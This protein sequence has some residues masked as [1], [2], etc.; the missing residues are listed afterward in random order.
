MFS[1]STPENVGISSRQ[2]LKYLKMIESHGLFSH[3]ILIARGDKLICEAYW[4]PFDSKTRHRMYSQTKS[5]VG[6]AIRLLDYEGR[7]SLD[8]RIIDY[9]P[10]KLPE[11]IHPYLRKL[12]IRNM[13]MMRTCFD[14]HDINWFTSGTDDRVKLYFSQEPAVYPGTQFRYDSM[15]S[16]VL[17]A[18][19]EKITGKTF[20]DYLREKCLDEIGF[21]K[22]AY[23]LKCPGGFSWADSALLC[24]P[25]DMLKF[26]RLIGC[27]GRWDGRQIIPE[28]IIA[29]A[30][31]DESD[32]FYNGFYSFDNRGYAS[33]L[34]R[35]Y[36]NSFGFNGMHDQLTF[37]DPDT[38]ITFTC[39]SG[40]YRTSSSRELLVSYAF[41]EIVDTAED[42][43]EEDPEAY[44]ELEKYIENLQLV[45]AKG[46]KNSSLEK[47]ID[48][49]NFIAESNKMG[50]EKFSFTF[51][52]ECIFKY[53][54]AQG[55]K[56]IKF[57]KCE[58]VFQPFP[59]MGYPDEV[60]TVPCEGNTYLCAASGAW[61]TEN[62]LNIIVQIIDKYI[63]ILYI[64]FA[65]CD[66]HGRIKMTADA[67]HFLKE[68]H[69]TLNA[70]TE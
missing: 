34:W 36:G 33:Q 68:Y 32:C 28:K 8:D 16:F 7:A 62:Q 50:I 49:R 23:C 70:E 55:V 22:D 44:A 64:N 18:L 17:G 19:V 29:D 52:D 1:K 21:S 69:G 4:K 12:T 30:L 60:G 41:S 43:M 53:K 61:G 63:G 39:T 48:G 67:E 59:Q 25:L 14:E 27:F 37:Y 45:T 38:D 42:K 40:N 2:I 5:F 65:Y 31:S 10:E 54:N 58:N 26:G 13:L 24:T 51:G 46:R 35:F 20:L 9:F 57:K 11:E 3:S 66:G 56:E 47:K 6:I 15:G